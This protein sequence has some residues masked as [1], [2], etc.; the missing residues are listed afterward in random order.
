MQDANILFSKYLAGRLR[1]YGYSV[2]VGPF[3]A[4][5]VLGPSHMGQGSLETRRMCDGN[6]FEFRLASSP[7]F[8]NHPQVCDTNL[9]QTWT[10]S[11]DRDCCTEFLLHFSTSLCSILSD[12]FFRHAWSLQLGT[13]GL[14]LLPSWEPQQSSA[15]ASRVENVQGGG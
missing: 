7:V 11:S 2:R 14:P 15:R 12:A 1:I 10:W 9:R 5:F 6:P 8:Q 3:E 4:L 13:I